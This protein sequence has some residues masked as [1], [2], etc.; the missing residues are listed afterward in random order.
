MLKLENLSYKN[1]F[2]NINLEVEKWIIGITGPSGSWKTTF[3]KI[4][5]WFIKA[6]NGEVK[7]IKKDRIYYIKKWKTIPKSDITISFH[8]QDY[9]LLNLDVK[10]NIE[11]PFILNKQKIDKKWLDYLLDYFEIKKLYNKK[12]ENISWWEKERVSIV[13]CFVNKP[14][15]VLL[16]EAW[17][18]LDNKLKLKL[19]NFIKEYSKEN[20]I[21]FVSHDQSFIDYFKLKNTLY[22]NS[23]KILKN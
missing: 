3:L 6:D 9:L 17:S 4:V 5:W 1:L 10:T 2:H 19:Y 14:N 15:L 7:I 16:D 8:F 21:F 11:L 22:K 13:R 12:I 20:T 23:L 18:A